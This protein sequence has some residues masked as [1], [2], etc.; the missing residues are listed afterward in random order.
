VNHAM[1]DGEVA[2]RR[3]DV[4]ATGLERHAVGRRLNGESRVSR[5]Q[6]GQDA[7]VV[8]SE[9]LDHDE[10]HAFDGDVPDELANGL[11]PTRGGSNARDEELAIRRFVGHLVGRLEWLLACCLPGDLI[12][13]GN[14][15]RLSRC[16]RFCRLV[17]RLFVYAGAGLVRIWHGPFVRTAQLSAPHP[18]DVPR[19]P[20][21]LAP[22]RRWPT[23]TDCHP[24]R[25]DEPHDRRMIDRWPRPCQRLVRTCPLADEGD[26][27]VSTSF[28][29]SRGKSRGARG[30]FRGLAEVDGHSANTPRIRTGW[31][32][33]SVV[34]GIALAPLSAR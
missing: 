4:D 16:G 18:R 20:G 28:L 19:D 17:L 14:A 11:E 1:H 25:A 7:L 34:R 10:R 22:Q 33:A 32:L 24:L 13:L 29:A 27:R 15:G 12:C 3:D 9:V 6:L 30:F 21:R 8:G 31:L 2:V 26:A 5:Q 23:G